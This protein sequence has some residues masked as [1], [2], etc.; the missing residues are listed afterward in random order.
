MRE[1][2]AQVK[3]V[4]I[5]IIALGGWCIIESVAAVFSGRFL[6]PIAALGVPG[7]VALLNGRRWGRTHCAIFL[8]VLFSVQHLILYLAEPKGIVLLVA[9]DSGVDLGTDP[10]VVVV[11]YVTMFVA[12]GLFVSLW[13]RGA[14]SYF[15]TEAS[16]QDVTH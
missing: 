5:T 11:A 12:I 13:S 6:V 15:A 7:A 3:V 8:L 2:P 14:N 1:M 4:G 9:R 16:E 10:T